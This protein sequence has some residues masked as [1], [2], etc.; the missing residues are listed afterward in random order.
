MLF[1]QFDP[2]FTAL[3]IKDYKKRLLLQRLLQRCF[4]LEI[5]EDTV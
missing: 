2:I 5:Q 3:T 1:I 4:V